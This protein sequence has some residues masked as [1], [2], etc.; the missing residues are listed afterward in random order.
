MDSAYECL[1]AMG[2][3]TL[4]F[5]MLSSRDLRDEENMVNSD[6]CCFLCKL[7]MPFASRSDTL[8]HAGIAPDGRGQSLSGM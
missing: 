1:R 3:V 7:W 4:A 5:K 8:C 6:C 2:Q